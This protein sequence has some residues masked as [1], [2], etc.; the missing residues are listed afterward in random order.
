MPGDRIEPPPGANAE[1]V[2]WVLRQLDQTEY[3]RRQAPVVLRVSPKAF[4]IG[5]R[6]PIVHRSGWG[7]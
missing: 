6:L 2:A 5:R 3:K 1:T 7:R 4:G